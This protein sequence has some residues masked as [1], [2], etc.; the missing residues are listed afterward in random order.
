MRA[1]KNTPE[2]QQFS[3]PS[4]SVFYRAVSASYAPPPSPGSAVQG[5]PQGLA[6]PSNIRVEV[7]SQTKDGVLG[8]LKKIVKLPDGSSMKGSDGEY[9]FEADRTKTIVITGY[10]KSA[11]F[12]E[13]LTFKAR[14]GEA[15]VAYG[16]TLPRYIYVSED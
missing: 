8:Y 7:T 13:S 14:Q 6:E 12:G 15:K 5:Q 16:R 11:T 3:M 1:L 2:G 9:V 10:P 4:D